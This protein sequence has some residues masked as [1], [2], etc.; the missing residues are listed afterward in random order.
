M[1]DENDRLEPHPEGFRT[2]LR[3]GKGLRG[4]F[5]ITIKDKVQA[6]ARETKLRELAAMLTAAGNHAE[7][8]IVLKHAAAA[9][10]ERDFDEMIALAEKRCGGSTK[11]QAK[12]K[13]AAPTFAKVGGWWTD[14]T[15]AT[16]YPDH[17]DTKKTSGLDKSRL[18][19]INAVVVAPGLT[20]GALPIDAVKLAH[21]E[22]VM[23]ALPKRAKRPATRRH[24]A[25]LV[26][27]TLELAVYPLKLIKA[28]PLPKG[29][30][31]KTGKPPAFAYLY[32]DEDAK[33]LGCA[34]VPL[35]YRLLWGFL[36]REGC[37]TGEAATMRVG[38]EIDLD[39]GVCSLSKNKTD[40]PRAWAL[41]RAVKS[42]LVAYVKLRGLK[43]GDLIFTDE[44][45]QQLDSARLADVVRDHLETAGVDRDELHK[46][47]ENRGRFRAHDLRGT[48]VTLSLANG[49]TETWVQ[50]R[51]GHQSSDMINRYRRAARSAA[52]LGL[53]P[54]HQLDAVIPELAPVAQGGPKGGPD[55][56]N[57]R[58]GAPTRRSRIGHKSR[59]SMGHERSEIETCSGRMPRP[60]PA[61]LGERPSIE[62]DPTRRLGNPETHE[63]P[64]SSDEEVGHGDDLVVEASAEHSDPVEG[65]LA[66]GLRRAAAAGAWDAV[67]ELTREL[68]ARREA[69]NHVVRLHTERAL[70]AAKR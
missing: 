40:D 60:A 7:T 27:R 33:L 36:A 30:M 58:R 38:Y 66:D 56:L 23:A 19:V 64:P 44:E 6:K 42:A 28:N 15:L 49:K 10:T 70:R 53:G 43:R 13:R 8:P 61:D 32:P 34:A 21:V 24:Y 45:G 67:A 39:R 69:R 63:G 59:G 52:E 41:D 47:G 65:A 18:H 26:H 51:T 11:A 2:R 37:R 31:P 48:F 16:D 9:P 12:E 25:Q 22:M 54:L 50:D 5:L 1:A 46:A 29:F 3:Y 35:C 57:P 68:R 4:R 62:I 20:F 14:G 55:R 17:V